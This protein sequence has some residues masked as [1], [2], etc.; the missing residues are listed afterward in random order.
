MTTLDQSAPVRTPDD[1]RQERYRDGVFSHAVETERHRLHLLESVLDGHTAARLDSF[2]V[3]PG[4]RCLEVGGGAG[5]VARWMANRGASV[6][7]TDL[8]T[9]FLGELVDLGVRV[10]RHDMY[11]ED[12]PPDSFDLIHLRYVLVHLPDQERAI[13]RLVSWLAPGGILVVEEPAFFPIAGSPHPA[14]R[15]VMLAFREYLEAAVGTRTEW[16]RSLPLPLRGKGL[17]DI[18]ADARFQTIRGGDNEAEW[19]RLTLEQSRAK[20]VE[21][22]LVP[23]EA[24]DEAYAEL[25]DPAFRDLSLAVFTAWGRRPT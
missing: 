12:F 3:A 9:S 6:T 7:V 2:G 25:T 1:W 11:T 21:A 20:I 8:D 14:Y 13:E 24:F 19:W 5:S 10:L 4:W 16:A 23:D 17:V 15:R 22:G 18:D